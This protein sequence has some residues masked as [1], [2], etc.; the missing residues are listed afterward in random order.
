MALSYRKAVPLLLSY[1]NKISQYPEISSN[2]FVEDQ[3]FTTQLSY[4]TLQIE[5][6]YWAVDQENTGQG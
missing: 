5:C 3:I 4:E 6:H 2:D 1:L